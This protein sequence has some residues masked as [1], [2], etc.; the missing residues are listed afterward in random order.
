MTNFQT[1]WTANIQTPGLFLFGNWLWLFYSSHIK[2]KLSLP[3]NSIDASHLDRYL[4]CTEAHK[5]LT[6]LSHCCLPCRLRCV[7]FLSDANLWIFAQDELIY[8]EFPK[9]AVQPKCHALKTKTALVIA[10]I[11]GTRLDVASWQDVFLSVLCRN[12]SMS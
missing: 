6:L 12:K 5:W 4:L 7:V 10:I 8:I 1:F 9:A 2:L 3:Q 11:G